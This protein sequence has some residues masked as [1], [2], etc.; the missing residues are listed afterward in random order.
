MVLDGGVAPKGWGLAVVKLLEKDGRDGTKWSDYRCISLVSCVAKLF[1]RVMK[2]RVEQRV[3]KHA[4]SARQY[5]FRGGYS[6]DD[7]LLAFAA[8][9]G[10]GQT[11]EEF[12][13]LRYTC[14]LDVRRA[15]PTMDRRAMLVRLYKKGKVTGR[16][17]RIL[18]NMYQSVHSQIWVGDAKGQ[19]YEVGTGAREGS[20]LSPICYSAGMDHARAAQGEI[21]GG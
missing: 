9:T 11:N 15:F 13:A 2:V 3:H 17:W 21:G 12:G 1:E 16:V 4:T 10:M 20:V 14:F 6:M 18:A 5:G 7:A 8:T 19:Q